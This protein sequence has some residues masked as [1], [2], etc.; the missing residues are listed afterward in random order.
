MNSPKSPVVPPISEA[1][2][3]T[4]IEPEASW[5]ALNL[6]D[7]LIEVI[8]KA[9]YD[10][11][12]PVQQKS[13]PL[14]IEGL[15]LLVSSQT[16]SGKT[17]AFALPMIEKIRGREG[18]KGL[19]LAPSREIALQS[20]V[21]LS[22]FGEDL[23]IKA[24]A[25]IG[26][27]ELRIDEQ[28]LKTYPQIII[29]TPGR[30]CDHIE[31]GN[32]WLDFLEILVLDEADRMLEMG[33]ASQLN[34][35]LDE[36]PTSRQTLLFSATIPTPV[37]K[38]AQRILY[39]P[40]RISIGRPSAEP[41]KVDQ[42][43]IHLDASEKFRALLR[44]LREEKG[45]IF[46]FCGSKI[47]VSKLWRSLRSAGFYDATQLHSDLRQKDREQALADF[48]EGKY[49]V[50]IATDVIGRGIHVDGVNHVVNYDLPRE[51]SD[52]VHRIGRTGR[53]DASGKATSF[54]MHSPRDNRVF[55]DIEKIIGKQPV[56]ERPER[57]EAT[58]DG[59][60]HRGPST[61]HSRKIG[62]SEVPSE[63]REGSEKREQNGE[64]R[65]RRRNQKPEG[66]GRPHLGAGKKQNQPVRGMDRIPGARSPS[67]E[68]EAD[69]ADHA[70]GES[71][72]PRVNRIQI[73]KKPESSETP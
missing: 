68:R 47:G 22:K 58:S 30:L 33:F 37:E 17:A 21:V 46:I 54:V 9:G 32:L 19:I 25:L 52:Y 57:S 43:F 8:R 29:A 24:V 45:T 60:S 59:K 41:A 10:K 63:N 64:R 48:K 56:P 14:A 1:P 20:Q 23:G 11:P 44:L 35:I 66:E 73:R 28:A 69:S 71:A 49:R 2:L 15:D 3:T 26:G 5:A 7:T 40:E 12:T 50:I 53:A 27:V 16:G 4:P 55:R 65:P 72:A 34:R 39:Q 31:R 38:M 6:S 36:L 18:L 62:R 67:D 51:A 13:I 61:T 42:F 70:S